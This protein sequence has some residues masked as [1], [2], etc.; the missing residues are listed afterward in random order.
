MIVHHQIFGVDMEM[1]N[2]FIHISSE[3]LKVGNTIVKLNGSREWLFGVMDSTQHYGCW[4]KG[5]SPLGAT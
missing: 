1:V 3:S 4:S 5:S 2:Q